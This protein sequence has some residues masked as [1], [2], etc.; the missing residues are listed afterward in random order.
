[1]NESTDPQPL[2]PSPAPAF[3]GLALPVPLTFGQILDRTFRLLRTHFRLLMSVA[4]IPSAMVFVIV[5][6]AVSCMLMAMGP[7][8]AIRP[9]TPAVLP[10]CLLLIYGLGYP[11]AF[12]VY[13]LYMSA[14]S[15]A[16]TQAD[17]GVP[18]S[19]RQAYQAAWSRFGRSLWLML[20]CI[21]YIVVP[22]IVVGALILAGIALLQHAAGGSSGPAAAFF[23]VP[24]LLLLYLGTLVYSGYI[25]MRFSVAYPACME[26]DLA[27]RASLRRSTHLTRGAMGR[28][29]L[30]LLVIY[31][32][33]YA[34]TLVL[35]AALFAVALLGA[36]AATA[37]HVAAGSPA[38]FILVGLGILG[39]TL[40]LVAVSAFFYAALTT[41]LAVLYHDQRLRKDSPAPGEAR[42]GI[43][44]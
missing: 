2:V 26:E 4:L 20:L 43:S 7:Q 16:A 37:A 35:I 30:V 3:V 40:V 9:G 12:L 15:F 18:I 27:A 31:A 42:S 36:L 25:L 6:A 38:F 8:M 1:M 17:L 34:V 21:F 19:F 32:A 23:L 33:M 13:A 22:V 24:L 41:T 39:G 28:I 14:G 10:G 44:G 11:L 29:F 5:G